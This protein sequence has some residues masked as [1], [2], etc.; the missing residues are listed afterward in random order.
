[1]DYLHQENKVCRAGII[2]YFVDLDGYT[3]LLLGRDAQT[4]RWA[5]LGGTT[6]PGETV[7]ETALREYGEESRWSLPVQPERFT[8][9]V[10]TPIQTKSGLWSEQAFCF[11]PVSP[12]LSIDDTFQQTVPQNEYEA[13]MTQ[14]AWIDQESVATM[15]DVSRSI[16]ALQPVL[17][18]LSLPH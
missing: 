8:V 13:E 18:R 2:P 16:A 1:M 11:V 17:L 10:T 15:S 6:E 3:F 4:G 5:D 9:L 14:L 7:L 12:D